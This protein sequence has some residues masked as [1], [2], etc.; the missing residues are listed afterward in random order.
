[1][2]HDRSLSTAYD[3]RS[4][5][6]GRQC[7]RAA[8]DRSARPP[9]SS[10]ST[11]RSTTGTT[12]S[13]SA[14]MASSSCAASTRTRFRACGICVMNSSA[15][16]DANGHRVHRP[17]RLILRDSR[18]RTRL[19]RRIAPNCG[20]SSRIPAAS[21]S[22]TFPSR[23]ASC[24]HTR[25]RA[26]GG[27]TA[28]R[29]PTARF[30]AVAP[31]T[32]LLRTDG[33]RRP[34]RDADRARASGQHRSPCI[35]PSRLPLGARAMARGSSIRSRQEPEF[36]S[37]IDDAAITAGLPLLRRLPLA[38]GSRAIRFW[39][40]FGRTEPDAML[41]LVDNANV[42]SGRLLY[43]C[44]HIERVRHTPSRQPG[45]CRSLRAPYP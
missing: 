22:R 30:F 39:V 34:A 24:S 13:T 12:S 43:W 32:Y 9:S 14:V 19:D 10:S 38:N 8:S 1:M 6:V 17:S 3:H 41:E 16:I 26:S 29:R 37:T 18:R 5:H 42:I 40:G 15:L 35:S 20:S 7:E 2:V 27:G 45:P 44:E 36:A 23:R 33:N 11:D 28:T 25:R 21:G 31:G 4:D